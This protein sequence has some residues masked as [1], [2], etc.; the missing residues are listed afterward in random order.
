MK[1]L[2]YNIPY[3]NQ[4][5]NIRLIFTGCQHYGSHQFARKHF[6]RFLEQEMIENT[7]LILFGDIFD[8]IVASDIKR[9]DPV[10]IADPKEVLRSRQLNTA[11]KNCEDDLSP[12]SNNILGIMQGNHEYQFAKRHNLC[13]TQLLCDKLGCEN[14]GMSFLMRLLLRRNNLDRVR[15]VVLYGHHGYGASST[16]GS[17]INKYYKK[18]QEFDADVF[19][20]AHDHKSWNV[21]IPRV[22][23]NSVGKI[24]DK[25]ILMLCAGTFKKALSDDHIPTWEELKGFGP[26]LLGG[27]IIEIV[28]NDKS[29]V[30]IECIL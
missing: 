7:Y 15:S 17:S 1:I 5:K 12:Y 18:I 23:I 3:S 26:N 8:A 30:N 27:K 11:L 24:Y 29:G 13:L 9:Y 10:E 14:L 16:F 28:P 6:K 2:K 22:G 21:K 25:S 20:F 4:N 19:V